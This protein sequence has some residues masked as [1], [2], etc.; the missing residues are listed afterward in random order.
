MSTFVG[1]DLEQFVTDPHASGIQRVL[2]YVARDWP[3]EIPA[4]FVFPRGDSLALVEPDVAAD[5]VDR[6]FE[7]RSSE[8]NLAARIQAVLAQ[9][10]FEDL[11]R[12]FEQTFSHWLVPEVSYLPAVLQRARTMQVKGA[13]TMIGYDALPMTQPTNYRFVPGHAAEVSEYFRLLA[14]A[15][16]VVAISDYS[17]H[18][19]DTALRRRSS[20][21]IAHPGGDHIPIR[22]SQPPARTRFLRVGTLEARKFP[23][24]IV[25]AFEMAIDR[26]MQADLMF[27]GRPSASDESINERLRSSIHAG[28]PIS[29]LEG[30]PDSVVREAMNT[31]TY[32]LSIGVEGYGIPVLESIRMGTPVLFGG[33]QPAAEL[34]VRGG[35]ESIAWQSTEELADSLA[36]A[37]Q[38]QP[39][40]TKPDAVPTWREFVS[41]VTEA[42]IRPPLTS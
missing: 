24:E 10:P 23:V 1:I 15:Q 4:A 9:L 38:S 27:I 18:S 14:Q 7:E 12:P 41:R 36:S 19:I 32:F 11:A 8:D 26:G 16:H 31:S 6:A 28:Y 29:W 33:T 17:R 40:A 3:R 30:A 13:L 21:D 5:L 35:A 42:T 2:Q 22:T 20:T 25:A 39:F 34:M 37:A